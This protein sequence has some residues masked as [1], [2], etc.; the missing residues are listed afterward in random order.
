MYI[1]EGAHV[2]PKSGRVEDPAQCLSFCGTVARGFHS[3]IFH[4]TL[5][6]F[7]T[8]PSMKLP[9]VSH[10]Q[11]S[12][13]EGECQPLPVAQYLVKMDL[14]ITWWD[15]HSEQPT[16]SDIGACL[17]LRVNVNAHIYARRWRGRRRFNVGRVLVVNH[18]PTWPFNRTSPTD[19]PP[20]SSS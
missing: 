13:Q 18:P 7:C 12:R 6:R 4:L 9:D 2:K 15:G 19:S 17:T 16:R 20:L 1:T 8:I 14:L 3:S 10:N 11:C 5:S